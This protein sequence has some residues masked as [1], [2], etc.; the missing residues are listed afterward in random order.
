MLLTASMCF[1]L[2]LLFIYTPIAASPPSS[3]PSPSHSLQP[4]FSSF[5]PF[6]LE[7]HLFSLSSILLRKGEASHW[8]Q[9]ALAYQVAVRLGTYFYCLDMAAQLGKRDPKA[10][11]EVKD[12]ARSGFWIPTWRPSCTTVH[13]CR[14][15]YIYKMEYYSTIFRQ[16]NGTRKDHPEWGNPEPKRKT[17]YILTCKWI[18]VI[19]YRITMLQSID[20]KKPNNKEGPREDSW[21]SLRRG[22]R[23]DMEWGG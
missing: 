11:N 2:F 14:G 23:L 22:N 18:L 21:I 17:W 19:K 8:Y 1:I 20:S 7:N 10:G 16:M 5:L 12:R 4:I 15:L 13:M 9:P 3:P 6:S